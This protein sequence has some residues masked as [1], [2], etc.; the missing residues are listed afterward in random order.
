MDRIFALFDYLW[1]KFSGLALYYQ[2]LGGS[3]MLY[4]PLRRYF[5]P[6][7][8]LLRFALYR[9]QPLAYLRALLELLRCLFYVGKTG[10]LY[11]AA[12]LRIEMELFNPRPPLPLPCVGLNTR[13]KN[14][15]SYLRDVSKWRGRLNDLLT[16]LA[17]DSKD[18]VAE[19]DVQTCFDVYKARE[20]LA[21]YFAAVACTAPTYRRDTDRCL[22]RLRIEQGCVAPL[23]LLTGLLNRYDQ[24]WSVVLDDFGRAISLKNDAFNNRPLR[25]LQTFLFDCWLLW[26][27]SIPLCSCDQWSGVSAM[28]YGYGDENNSIALFGAGLSDELADLIAAGQGDA[29]RPVAFQA[30]ITGVPVWGPRLKDANFC[31]A[32]Q[33]LCRDDAGLLLEF[34]RLEKIGS[35]EVEVKRRYYSA[36]LWIMFVICD[37]GGAPLYPDAPWRALLP[38]YEHGNIADGKTY[39]VLKLQLARKA[40]NLLQETA[41]TTADLRF[42]FVCAFDD[43]L[44]GHSAPIKPPAPTLRSLLIENMDAHPALATR[45]ILDT[46][47]EWHDGGYSACHLPDLITDY[48]EHIKQRS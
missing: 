6:A 44:C 29:Q 30:S 45:V 43:T 31:V 2:I 20:S 4:V 13:L 26:G 32:Q 36:Y 39:A 12:R 19:L 17:E 10:S 21:C 34:V 33:G 25:R 1:Q 40:L 15:G 24:D 48:Y 7:W 37:V 42:R 18:G 8:R 28:Q 46:P 38:I 23:Y 11:K 5:W 35:R 14:L 9:G 3:V 27:P 22:V 47:D 16:R 41:A